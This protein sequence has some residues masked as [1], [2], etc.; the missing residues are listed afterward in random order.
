MGSTGNVKR[1]GIF[2]NY[3]SLHAIVPS[4]HIRSIIVQLPSCIFYVNLLVHEKCKN[5]IG[6]IFTIMAFNR[7]KGQKTFGSFMRRYSNISDNYGEL[8]N[9]CQVWCRINGH[10]KKNLASWISEI[11]RESTFTPII[12]IN[13]S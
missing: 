7:N 11:I 8:V 13:S 2:F 3:F 12:V 10:R 9:V 5:N 4:W 6:Q 1:K